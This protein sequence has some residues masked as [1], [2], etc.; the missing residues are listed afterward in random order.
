MINL[1]NFYSAS[2][3]VG[4]ISSVVVGVVNPQFVAAPLCFTG[5]AL[6]GASVIEKKRYEQTKGISTSGRVSGAF[7]VLY[8]TNRGL[9]TSTSLALGAEVDV[10]VAEAYLDALA[11]ETGGK[12]LENPQG[13]G[14]VYNFPHAENVLNELSENAQKWAQQEITKANQAA[15]TLSQQLEE[16]QQLIRVAQMAQVTAPRQTAKRTNDDL[17]GME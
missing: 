11:K 14:V 13:D 4:G 5:G 12:R 8:E 2:L 17:W 1:L 7:K 6:A 9:I 3:A 16:A 15:L 10:Q